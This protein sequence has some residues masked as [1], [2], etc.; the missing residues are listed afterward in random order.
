VEAPGATAVGGSTT[1][2][3]YSGATPT[4]DT[5][6]AFNNTTSTYTCPLPG[7]YFV[8]AFGG[9]DS[10]TL[11]N[12]AI[13][14]GVSINGTSY[15][16]APVS[17]VAGNPGRAGKVQVFSLNAGD[18]IQHVMLQGAGAS[19]NTSTTYGSYF[20]VLWLGYNS[21]PG[22][23]PSA[24]DPTY[25]FTA[26]TNPANTISAFQNHIANDLLFL[27][28]KPYTLAYQTV[29]QTGIANQTWTPVSMSNNKGIVHADSAVSYGGW[30]TNTYTVPRTGYYLCVL[31][32]SMA[33]PSLTSTPQYAAGFF[34]VPSGISNV[35]W[36]GEQRAVIGASYGGGS[37]AVAIYYLRQGDTIQP[38]TWVSNV[39]ST[40]TSTYVGSTSQLSHFEAV[41]LSG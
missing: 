13:F 14:T 7:L 6:G 18:T 12:A 19:L 35:D 36:F 31:E 25:L 30:S 23:L 27:T 20:I 24:P 39:S 41:W 21:T 33:T 34:V 22:T 38:A 32:T 40:T 10:P 2:V 15:F 16:G 17:S 29:A 26:G 5:Y 9:F 37:T 8:A 3:S 1:T 28:Q 4:W 11:T